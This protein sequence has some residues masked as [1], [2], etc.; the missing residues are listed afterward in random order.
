LKAGWG[1]TEVRYPDMSFTA[2]GLAYALINSALKDA[3]FLSVIDIMVKNSYLGVAQYS[4]IEISPISALFTVSHKGAQKLILVNSGP[5]SIK[6]KLPFS[7]SFCYSIGGNM[8]FEV[9]QG[10]YHSLGDLQNLK[11]TDKNILLKP[12][13]VALLVNSAY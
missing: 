13:S 12:F 10:L 7:P 6:V 11:V 8:M 3:Q 4:D 1:P 5:D 2:N 9:R